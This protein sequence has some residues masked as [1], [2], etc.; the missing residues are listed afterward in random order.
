[1]EHITYNMGLLKDGLAFHD[2]VDR[3]WKLP[4][5]FAPN[6]YSCSVHGVGLADEYPCIYHPQ[7]HNK[8]GYNG[9]FQEN[10][11]V[12]VESYT[13]GVGEKEGVKLEQQVRIT[14]TGVE[15][16]SDFAIGSFN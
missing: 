5:R 1:M 6:R 4:D 14:K 3:S 8:V 10:M 2:F 9:H 13:G 12:C 15:L 11:V 7:D 16:L